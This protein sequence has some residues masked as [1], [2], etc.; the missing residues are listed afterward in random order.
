MLWCVVVC[1]YV[2]CGVGL[3]VDVLFCGVFRCVVLCC[4]VLCCVALCCGVV[5]CVCRERYPITRIGT[6]GTN[7]HSAK[8][9]HTQRYE[10]DTK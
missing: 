4:G 10:R 6:H 5:C 8:G 2:V 3:C 1:G 7:V 9:Q